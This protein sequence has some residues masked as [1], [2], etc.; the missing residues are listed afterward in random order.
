MEQHIKNVTEYDLWATKIMQIRFNVGKEFNDR[1]SAFALEQLGRLGRLTPENHNIWDWGG[2]DFEQLKKM[3][4]YSYTRYAKAHGKDMDFTG[5]ENEKYIQD[6]W[7][8]IYMNGTYGNIHAHQLGDFTAVYY[9][10]AGVSNDGSG[11][12]QL[13]DPRWMP[14]EFL[15]AEDFDSQHCVYPEDGTMLIFPGYVWHLVPP[16]TGTFPRI[17]FA[18]MFEWAIF[19]RVAM[20]ER[21]MLERAGR[22]PL[23]SRQ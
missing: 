4:L 23:T 2:P 6:A 15:Y 5:P 18:G 10:S 17:C 22:A 16:Y 14:D 3:F 13:S 9:S 8:Q 19:N 21:K 1:I 11:Y 12:V 7:C 20:N